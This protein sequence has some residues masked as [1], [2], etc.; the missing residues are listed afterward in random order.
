[1]NDK[2]DL[3][4]TDYD[5]NTG[6]FDYRF[7]ANKKDAIMFHS[8]GIICAVLASIVM[9]ALGSTNGDA[10]NMTYVLGYPLWWVCGTL[11]YLAMLVWGLNRIRKWEEFPLTARYDKEAK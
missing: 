10:S 3:H 1:M 6:D 9:Y 4:S 5:P 8:A 2:I 11:I 7:E